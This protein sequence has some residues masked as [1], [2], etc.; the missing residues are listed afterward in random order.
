MKIPFLFTAAA[1]VAAGA[2]STYALT[3]QKAQDPSKDKQAMEAAWKSFSSPGENHKVLNAKAG[4]W[5]LKVKDYSM[6]A[7]TES[8]A[9]SEMKWV[10]DNRFL[11]DNTQGTFMGQPFQ[12]QGFCGYDNLKKKYIGSW[13]DNMGTGIMT[14]EGTYDAASKTFTY[15]SECP[16]MTMTKYVKSRMTEKITDND[17]MTMQMYGPGPDG[18]EMLKMEIDY[19]RAK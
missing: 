10:M 9:T 5:T 8:T 12:G 15:T 1:L 2:A 11:E 14:S 3:A 6:G 7:P 13:I 17:H 18:K 4:K 16:D 19:T